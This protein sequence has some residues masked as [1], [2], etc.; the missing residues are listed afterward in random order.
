M[1]RVKIPGES[2][3]DRLL[4]RS[5]DRQYAFLLAGGPIRGTLLQGS[6]LLRQ[7]QVNH[8]LGVWE[9]I[10]QG[11]AYLGTL[12]MASSLKDEGRIQLRVECSGPLKGLSVEADN[13][14]TV[15]G[16]LFE[17]SL[18]E[19][20][21]SL[22]T[23]PLFGRGLLSLTRYTGSGGTPVTGQVELKH[24]QVA[25]DLANYYLES[26]QVNTLISLSVLLDREGSIR[27]GVG[28]LVQAL[29]GASE[30]ILQE[31][32]ETLLALPSL[33]EIFPSSLGGEGFLKERLGVFQPEVLGSRRVEFFCSCSRERFSQFLQALAQEEKE[34]I[35]EE[36]PF[37]L[38]VNCYNCNSLYSFKRSELLK[39]F[40]V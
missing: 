11:Q 23:A 36:G 15:R 26:E 1:I 3:K 27:G 13:H 31:V 40:S 32:E 19:T 24:G 33:G 4:A 30:E 28:L 20:P 16:Y 17:N 21:A 25:K 22:D 38:E 2:E 5:R 35:L 37:P 14:G 6:H 18:Q 7:M 8:G 34:R 9:S 10:V 29:P 39:F 12:L